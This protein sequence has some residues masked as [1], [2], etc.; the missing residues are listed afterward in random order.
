MK[1]FRNKKSVEAMERWPFWI[2]FAMTAVVISMIIVNIANIS[3]EEASKIPSGLED[4]FALASRFYNSEDCFAYQDEV[5][6]VHVK[7]IDAGKFK[8]E[9]MGKCFPFSKVSYAFSLSLE[10]LP[11]PEIGS[12]LSFGT[13]PIKTFNYPDAGYAK[14]EIAEN[15]IVFYEGRKYGGKLTIKIKNV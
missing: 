3:I 8:Q 2:M 11:R 12:P 7:V 4:E 10:Q 6:G 13:S 5:G 9:N 15:V 1:I 14:K